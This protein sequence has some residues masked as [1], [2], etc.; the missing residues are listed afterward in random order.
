MTN[1]GHG[2]QSSVGN[3]YLNGLAAIQLAL[4]FIGVKLHKTGRVNVEKENAL[5]NGTGLWEDKRVP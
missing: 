4:T 5:D 2:R 1:I 3:L